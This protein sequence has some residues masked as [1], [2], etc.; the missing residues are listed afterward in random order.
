MATM[1]RKL[2]VSAMLAVLAMVGVLAVSHHHHYGRQL[3]HGPRGDLYALGD[4]HIMPW[5]MY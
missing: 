3:A 5:D 4:M 1:M 2:L